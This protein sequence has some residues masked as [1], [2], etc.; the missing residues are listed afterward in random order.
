MSNL[1]QKANE[2][3]HSLVLAEKIADGDQFMSD[4]QRRD[5]IREARPIIEAHLKEHF[6]KAPVAAA[7]P[8]KVWPGIETTSARYAN[9]Q[10]LTHNL[11]TALNEGWKVEAITDGSEHYTLFLSRVKPA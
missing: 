3:V 10:D 2:Q 7:Q 1:T 6:F 11:E 5:F 4:R 9:R 8:E